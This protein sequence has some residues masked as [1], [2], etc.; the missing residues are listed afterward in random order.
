MR[1]HLCY[2]PDPDAVLWW[3]GGKLLFTMQSS[4]G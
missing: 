2:R 1:R 4:G 3:L